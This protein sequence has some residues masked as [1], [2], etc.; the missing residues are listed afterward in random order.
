LRFNTTFTTVRS[1]NNGATRIPDSKK[2]TLVI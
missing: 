1:K 2:G